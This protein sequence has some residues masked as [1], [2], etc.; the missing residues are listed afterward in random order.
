MVMILFRRFPRFAIGVFA[1][2]LTGSA[3]AKD[4]NFAQ[5]PA[6]AYLSGEV[7]L[8]DFNGRD[9]AYKDLRTRIGNGAKS[10]VNFAGHVALLH[11]RAEGFTV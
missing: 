10:G 1:V 11:K 8:P 6:E 3:L 9:A 2:F 5:Y 7:V 4:V